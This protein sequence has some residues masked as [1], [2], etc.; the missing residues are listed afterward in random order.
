[1]VLGF[2]WYG[3]LF[4]RKWMEIIG[5]SNESEEAR[6]KMQKEAGP[7]YMVSFLLALFEAWV[8][9]MF[10]EGVS[11]FSAISNAFWIWLAFIVPVLA[12]SVM[13]TNEKPAMKKA[14]FLVQTG[15]QF[16]LLVGFAL[17]ISL[18]N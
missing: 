17:I 1:M 10:N 2:L 7:L 9:G 5:T 16:L 12:G 4:G 15:Y 18:L 6:K 13:W 14:R 3:P 8:L 11:T